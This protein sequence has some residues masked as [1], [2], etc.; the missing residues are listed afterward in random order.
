MLKG[1]D[2]EDDKPTKA[3]KGKASKAKS[4]SRSASKSQSK[5]A[6]PAA[7]SVSVKSEKPTGKASVSKIETV[8]TQ[9][10]EGRAT[11]SVKR[12]VSG[13]S[14][15]IVKRSESEKNTPVINKIQ[16]T[17][18]APSKAPAVKVVPVKQ[19]SKPAAA[20]KNVAAPLKKRD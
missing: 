16:S 18:V 19:E 20:K 17:K 15:P 5:K 9:P 11:P 8:K 3:R 6:T 1:C 13:R 2:D 7:R 14:T 10:E 4:K 12:A